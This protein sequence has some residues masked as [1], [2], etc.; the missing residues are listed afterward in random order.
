MKLLYITVYANDQGQ[1]IALTATTTIEVTIVDIN[2]NTP[3]FVG[4]DRD[5]CYHFRIAE[6]Q[7]P[8]SYVG[9]LLGTDNDIDENAQLYFRL[10]GSTSNFKL[11]STTGELTTLQLLDRE[12]QSNYELIVLL[13]DRGKPPRSST[14]KVHIHVTDINDHDP[15]VVFP[16]IARIEARDPDEGHNSLL[17]FNL[18][19]GNEA[20]IFRLGST[21]AELT[22]DRELTEQDIGV[23]PLVIHIQDAGIPSRTT[24]VKLVVKITDSLPRVHSHRFLNHQYLS[25]NDD[26]KSLSLQR[27]FKENQYQSINDDNWKLH[28]HN[29]FLNQDDNSFSTGS[30]LVAIVA[31][32]NQHKSINQFHSPNFTLYPN[33]SILLDKYNETTYQPINS[34]NDSSIFINNENQYID[35]I[36][37]LQLK[38]ILIENTQQ[39]NDH[40][41]NYLSINNNNNN[42]NNNNKPTLYISSLPTT[43]LLNDVKLKQKNENEKYW[44]LKNC[45][46]L[47]QTNQ[48]DQNIL[49]F[50][51]LNKKHHHHQ[52]QQQ[53]QQTNEEIKEKEN[54]DKE[55]EKEEVGE[56]EE[57]KEEEENSSPQHSFKNNQVKTP[58]DDIMMKSILSVNNNQNHINVIDTTNIMNSSIR[59][60]NKTSLNCFKQLQYDNSTCKLSNALIDNKNN[61]NLLNYTLNNEHID[62]LNEVNHMKSTRSLEYIV[63]PH[64][65][66][67]I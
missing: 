34:L 58:S 14:V 66:E 50:I 43:F 23:Y 30:I 61:N 57:E 19:S 3:M 46:T 9:I 32:N 7:P 5:D 36:D 54:N 48:Y 60:N 22:I 11:N 49:S 1:P 67:K 38:S 33:K 31:L 2:D 16:V 41:T 47:P 44:T 42:N 62:S 53:Q 6:N 4:L 55:E 27:R 12:K 21:S 64:N 18:F 52:Q 51:N 8:N 15:I 17:H 37:K 45:Y 56:E 10:I 65:N 20:S 24:E 35:Q 40:Y 39:S 29:E 28:K 13:I 59:S 25:T 63:I 26:I